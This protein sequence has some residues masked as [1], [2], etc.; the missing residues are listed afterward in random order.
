MVIQSI[1]TSKLDA[2]SMLQVQVSFVLNKK[3]C[4][5]SSVHLTKS[6]HGQ[7]I[8]SS[9]AQLIWEFFDYK[10]VGNPQVMWHL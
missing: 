1:F 6:A 9:S 2:D 7:T 3:P 5:V 8:F 4:C 10:A